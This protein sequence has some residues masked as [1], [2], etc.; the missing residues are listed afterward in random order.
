ME[1]I[2]A[3]FV[4]VPHCVACSDGTTALEIALM[5]LNVGVG[6]EVITTPFTF[7]ASAEVIALRGARPVFVDIDPDTFNIAPERIESAISSRT[8]AIIAVSLFG[9]C[10]DLKTINEIAAKHGLYVIEDAA[11]SFG[12]THHGLRSGGLTTISTTSF[13]PSKPLGCY[14]DGGACF[15]R[16]SN[17]ATRMRQ[18]SLHGQ[19]RRYHHPIIGM[20]GRFD[21]LQAAVVLEKFKVFKEE[22]E[23]RHQA[24]QRYEALLSSSVKTPLIRAENTSVF[25]QYT[26]Q[27]KARDGLKVRLHEKGIPTAVHY[28][29][30]LSLQPAFVDLG[31]HSGDF[32]NAER[33]AQQVISLPM[34]PYL[35]KD[36]QE[37]ITHEINAFVENSSLR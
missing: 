37:A 36:A 30:P 35:S 9:Q 10:A 27:L 25:A 14:G 17:L 20:N 26:I 4:N 8:K 11:Q 29:I 15:T 33:A 24:A 3:E 34:H 12:A 2:L 16:N 31:Y 6:D 23:L 7:I 32:P 21:T 19:D 5:A 28:P 22:I 18:I 1:E 13:F